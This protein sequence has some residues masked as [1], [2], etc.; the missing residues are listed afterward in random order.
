MTI[1]STRGSIL[2]Q[3]LMPATGL[4]AALSAMGEH[5]TD[6]CT[7]LSPRLD[8]EPTPIAWTARY[9]THP[10][11]FAVILASEHT[12]ILWKPRSYGELRQFFSS[13]IDKLLGGD[14]PGVFHADTGL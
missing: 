10:P 7:T 4:G 11:G 9:I 1:A 14:F 3:L 6:A 2:C 5:R 8:G 12:A 13:A